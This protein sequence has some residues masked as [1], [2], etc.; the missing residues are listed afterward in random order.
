MTALLSL[1]QV[2]TELARKPDTRELLPLDQYTAVLVSFSGGKD[3]LRVSAPPETL[4][5]DL[6]PFG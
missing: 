6:H 3:S 4:N 5:Q 1:P 2:R